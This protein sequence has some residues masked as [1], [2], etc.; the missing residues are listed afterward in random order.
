MIYAIDV[1]MCMWY[2]YIYMRVYIYVYIMGIYPQ[3]MVILVR[4]NYDQP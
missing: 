1:Y 4:P 3:L 2:I